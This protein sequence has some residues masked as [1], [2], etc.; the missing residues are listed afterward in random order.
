MNRKIIRRIILEEFI[1]RID[2]T[3]ILSE[4]G[5]LVRIASSAP[6][7]ARRAL[8]R[9]VQTPTNA[10]KLDWIDVK[11]IKKAV[12]L[13]TGPVAAGGAGGG[14]GAAAAGGAAAG[15]I[16]SALALATAAAAG[17][18]AYSFLE[19]DSP[20][21]VSR[22]FE[23]KNNNLYKLMKP[24]LDMVENAVILTDGEAKKYAK[25][26]NDATLDYVAGIGAGT[27][28]KAL[29]SV[30]VGGGTD[31]D[32]VKE[33]IEDIGT[34][35]NL[36]RVSMVFMDVYGQ[37]LW[38]VI[39]DEFGKLDFERD[40][41]VNEPTLLLPFIELEGG[42]FLSEEEFL[43]E[44]EKAK[45]EAEEDEEKGEERDSDVCIIDAFP[46]LE[47][48]KKYDTGTLEEKDQKQK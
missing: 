23:S 2:N 38:N 8:A 15:G 3:Q 39:E 47:F 27:I 34:K 28:G 45:S 9:A 12:P 46:G 24:A 7:V 32:E 11:V 6:L 5:A 21:K 42:I 43:K 16:S 30:G 36:S 33:I 18:V 22:C 14:G 35:I 17:V 20:T 13:L 41:Y 1:K 26:F 31:E 37:N 40:E 44:L 10:G 19:A 25:R 48:I 29:K 4:S